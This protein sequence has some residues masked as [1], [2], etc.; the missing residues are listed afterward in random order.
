MKFC[1]KCGAQI[2]DEATICPQCQ[3]PT[4]NQPINVIQQPQPKKKA[5][6]MYFVIPLIIIFTALITFLVVYFVLPNNS[7]SEDNT[8]LNSSVNDA[9]TIITTGQCPEDKNGNHDWAPAKCT[10]PAQCYNCNAYRDDK[11]GQHKFYTDDDG[12]CDCTYCGIVYDV[13]IDS[14]KD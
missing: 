3:T 6:K 5:G 14:L 8:S 13:Y 1:E 4:N 9:S 12:F 2:N 7:K 10:E 11:L